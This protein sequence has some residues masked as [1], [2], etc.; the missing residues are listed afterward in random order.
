MTAL[1]DLHAQMADILASPTLFSYARALAFV[2][3]I[4]SAAAGGTDAD[5]LHTCEAYRMLCRTALGRLVERASAHEHEAYD[6]AATM[7]L[8]GRRRDLDEG[9]QNIV[10]ALEALR[11]GDYLG[12]DAHNEAKRGGWIV[13]WE[14]S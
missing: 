5:L 11:L 2:E 1:L 4:T 14:V 12:N 10:A 13:D 7:K 9:G 3:D 6:R 8:R